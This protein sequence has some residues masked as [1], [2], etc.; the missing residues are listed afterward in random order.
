MM[1]TQFSCK[2]LNNTKAFT[3]I[4]FDRADLD[5]SGITNIENIELSFHFYSTDDYKSILT[6]EQISITFENSQSNPPYVTQADT[7]APENAVAERIILQESGILVV[8]KGFREGRD[9]PEWEIFIENDSSENINV[10][11]E[12]VVVNGITTADSLF[13]NVVSGKKANAA[14]EFAASYLADAGIQVIKDVTFEI[15]V[16]KQSSYLSLI[17]PEIVSVECNPDIDY[18]QTY[19][20]SGIELLNRDGCR[21]VAKRL[22]TSDDDWGP[23]LLLYI[24]NTSGRYI[25]IDV[26]NALVNGFEINALFL[27][28]VFNN[29][30]LFQ[31]MGF[32]IVDLKENQITDIETIKFSFLVF[33]GEKLEPIFETEEIAITF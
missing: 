21:I 12:K 14:L 18:A 23:K 13:A 33:D 1:E 6:T 8:L 19:D 32:D 10:I 25:G 31:W 17:E 11:I 5:E 20:D 24:E 28:D 29:T 27:C 9:G 7:R 30:K 2:V 22:D 4:N 3:S 26:G 15:S 16:N